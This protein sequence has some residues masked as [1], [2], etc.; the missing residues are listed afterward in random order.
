[1]IISRLP[2]TVNNN[3]WELDP[4]FVVGPNGTGSVM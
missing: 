1:M 2:G 3:F 4:E